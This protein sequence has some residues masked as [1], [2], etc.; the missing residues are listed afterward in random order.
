MTKQIYIFLLLGLTTL[1]I[2][3]A[4]VKGTGKGIKQQ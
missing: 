2:F 3:G 1:K 4:T